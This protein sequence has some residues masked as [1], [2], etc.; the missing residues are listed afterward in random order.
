MT[1]SLEAL[2]RRLEADPFFLAC[3]LKHY[4]ES[5]RLDDEQLARALQCSA[6]TL[7]LVRLCRAPEPTHF[8]EDMEGIVKRFPVD[9]TALVQAVRQ[10]Q[11]LLHLAKKS[12][13]D[14]GTLLAAR[15]RQEAKDATPPTGD[16][17]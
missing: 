14:R 6:E 11:T 3:P 2:A 1:K 5:E 15:D 10:G 7:V 4:A 16:P 13:G 8:R 12:G 9:S 17:S